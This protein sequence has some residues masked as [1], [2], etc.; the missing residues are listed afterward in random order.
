MPAIAKSVLQH[1][2]KF[3]WHLGDF[4]LMSDVDDD[5]RALYKDGLTL[6]DYR[7][8]AWGDFLANQIAPF[9]L[10]PI[11]LGIGNHELYGNKTPEAYLTQ[12]AY[13]LDTPDL[14]T[15]RLKGHSQD[16]SLKPYYHWQER[17]I[18]FIYMDNSGDDGFDDAQMKWFED[19]LQRDRAGKD[20]TAVVVGMHRALPNSFAC[21]HSMNGDALNPS[22]K[23]T[24][25]GRQAYRDLVDWKKATG[26]LAYVLASHSHLFM[27]NIFG[28]DYW[29]NPQ[30]GGVVLPGWIVGTAGAKRYALPKELSPEV[31]AQTKA[32]TRVYGYLLATV[33]PGGTVEL[34]FQQLDEGD[35]PFEVTTSY[36]KEFVHRCF[37]ENSDLTQHPAPISCFEK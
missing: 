6:D 5:M 24:K 26:K 18:D 21:G 36:E 17:G 7:R 1:H 25:S 12:F 30:H 27:K 37:A 10:L 23:G 32:K 29:K 20:I 8:D 4:R 22:E 35:V 28:T 34:Q 15:Q 2:V 31:L 16:T 19:V 9:G 13:W 33:H 11:H 3:Y 14:R